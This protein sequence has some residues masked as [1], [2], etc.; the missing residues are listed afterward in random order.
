MLLPVAFDG[1]PLTTATVDCKFSFG[2]QGGATRNAIGIPV[3]DAPPIY[4]GIRQ[5]LRKLT[6]EFTPL[7]GTTTAN[8]VGYVMRQALSLIGPTG[9][10]LHTLVV[11]F[12]DGPDGSM[13]IGSG[14]QLEGQV[15][16][17]QYRY[18]TARNNVF[19]DLY[20]ADDR[21]SERADTVMSQLKF[22]G[23]IAIPLLNHGGAPVAPIIQLGYDTQR[24]TESASVGWKWR[25]TAT[26]SNTGD[27]PWNKVR[28]TIDLGDTSAWVT[29]SKALASGNDVRVRFAGRELPR[30][31]TNFNKARTLLHFYGTVPAG[32][33]N[34]YQILYGNPDAT[35]PDTIS[36]RVLGWAYVADD[37]EGYAAT[38]TAGTLSTVTVAGAGWETD[39][40][41]DAYIYFSAGPQ[42][43][44]RARRVLSNTGTVLTLNRAFGTACDN[45]T[46]FQ[47]WKSGNVCDGGIVTAAT[48]SSITDNLH[49]NKWAP[50]SMEGATVTFITGPATPSTMTVSS[51]TTDTLT[52]TGSFSVN[53]AAGNHYRIERWGVLNYMVDRSISGSAHRGLW[54]SRK[55]LSS[56]DEITFGDRIPG[57]FQPWLMVDNQDQ[58]AQIRVRD[59]TAG[60]VVSNWPYLSARRRVRSDLTM[61][62]KGTADGVCLYDPRG[63]VALDWDYRF[64]NDN[65]IGA[66]TVMAQ[67]PDGDDWETIAS[68]T[69][70]HASITVVSSGSGAAGGLSLAASSPVRLYLGMLPAGGADSEI[71][72]TES[73][74]RNAEVRS[75][76]R[77][78]V[79]LS[80]D[81]CG[82]LSSS[83]WSAGAEVAV[84]DLNVT[85]RLGGGAIGAEKPTYYTFAVGGSGHYFQLAATQKLWLNPSPTAEAP[86]LG[87]Y[88][89]TDALVSRAPYAAVIKRHEY[90][91]DGDDT[92][93]VDYQLSLQPGGN[94]ITG[95]DSITDWTIANSAGVTA[96]ISNDTSVL[97]DGGTQSLKIT[98]TTTPAGA[99]TITLTRPRITVVPGHLYEFGFL[100]RRVSLTNA[101]TAEMKIVWREPDGTSSPFDLS[102]TIGGAM[103]SA[104]TWYPAGTGRKV[105][106]GTAVTATTGADV[107]IIISGTGSTSGSINLD[108]IT[109]GVPNLYLDE[110]E[111]GILTVDIKWPEQHYA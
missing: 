54:R 108:P 99:W 53:P 61:P 82:G 42:G 71:A 106:T 83:I 12:S 26:I 13:T 11:Q 41:V 30:T 2:L 110:A 102:Q 97:W 25:R 49:T 43:V 78:I 66:V 16:V 23:P 81:D 93:L 95:E 15:G 107:S 62:E 1:K 5:D 21:W 90:N 14:T 6:I 88:D 111:I 98:V 68:D 70:T 84:Y 7:A 72:S 65:G 109:L 64:E 36:N 18:G 89:S 20:M 56:G 27:R 40:W 51:N 22:S 92:E 74:N 45:T 101:I 17:G 8:D 96:S 24:V 4:A 28:F 79:F 59:E 35:A 9:S 46:V 34:V 52:F 60:S 67:S 47:M 48:A 73:K 55:Y 69:T 86:L 39:R 105:H 31:L 104:S 87:L 100:R 32:A 76:S 33:S 63:L 58:F 44:A 94:L 91:L 19:V 38:A 103:A 75:N 3:A 50:D 80:L 29:G 37:L 57:G 85:G 10:D 77:T